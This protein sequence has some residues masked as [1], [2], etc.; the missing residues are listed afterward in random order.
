[1]EFIYSLFEY[2]FLSQ[3][4]IINGVAVTPS[5]SIAPLVVAGIAAAI[6][7]AST[8]GSAAAGAKANKKNQEILS[9]RNRENEMMYLS[10]YYRGALEN[11]GS[12]A[13]LKRLEQMM[14]KRYK[15]ADNSAVASAATQENRLAAK[16][17]NNEVISDAIAG[18]IEKEDN[19]KQAVQDRYFNNKAAIQSGQMAQNSAV[20]NNWAQIGAGISS[21]AGSLASAYLMD[22]N[23][24]LNPN[25]TT[26][27]TN[28][29]TSTI[30]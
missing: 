18:L 8:A 21:A 28:T 6:S 12:K 9:E 26:N 16:Q 7:A 11:D 1:M 17:A 25:A 23:Y 29:A 4:I 27:T 22:G 3:E 30:P 10:E 2:L 15:A 5:Y 19:R 24:K 20:A 13:Y 14:E